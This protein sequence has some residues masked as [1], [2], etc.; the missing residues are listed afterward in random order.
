MNIFNGNRKFTILCY[1]RVNICIF[2]YELL[3]NKGI[4]HMYCSFSIFIFLYQIFW[5]IF[6]FEMQ[7]YIC[8]YI[9]RI[10]HI[11]YFINYDYLLMI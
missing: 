2:N 4:I 6:F 10:I 1:L 9:Y 3:K 5:N 8:F 7:K 11:P